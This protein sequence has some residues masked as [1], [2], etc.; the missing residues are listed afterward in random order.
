[1]LGDELIQFG[2]AEPLGGAALPAVAAA[3][4]PAGTEWAAGLHAAGEPFA[5]IEAESLAA[6]EAP[7]GSLGG[8]A[9]LLADRARRPRTACRRRGAIEGEALRPPCPVHL[10]GGRRGERRPR[11]SAGSGAAGRAGP[12]S[13]GSDTPLGEETR[14]LPADAR[15]RGLRA[16]SSTLAGAGLSLHARPSRRRTALAGPLTIAVVQLGTF[17]AVAAGASLIT[18]LKERRS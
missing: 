11:V 5:L 13:S 16:R 3:A 1:M 17:A 10:R 15:R 12:G 7:P 4:R 18:R 14:T 6:I 8:E 9:R 2:A